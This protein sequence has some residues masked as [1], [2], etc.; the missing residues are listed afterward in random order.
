LRTVGEQIAR[1]LSS[2]GL[3]PE[4]YRQ[5]WGLRA[6]YPMVAASYAKARSELANPRRIVGSRSAKLNMPVR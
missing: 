6:D 1:H 2:R 5:K 4:H 3:T